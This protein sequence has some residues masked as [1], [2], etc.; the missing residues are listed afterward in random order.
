MRFTLFFF[1]FVTE[2]LRVWFS[3]WGGAT[4]RASAARK[5][6][7]ACVIRISQ[8]RNKKKIKRRIG[9]G[10]GGEEWGSE[11][12]REGRRIGSEILR[13]RLYLLSLS[14]MLT[15]SKISSLISPLLFTFFRQTVKKLSRYSIYTSCSLLCSQNY[16]LLEKLP[17][18]RR[19]S[20]DFWPI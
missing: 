6:V 4:G 3:I 15:R 10:G 9:V 8:T 11:S 14:K 17:C 12:G 18:L 5:E 7:K 19:S 13:I 20:F 1:F 2:F 16:Y